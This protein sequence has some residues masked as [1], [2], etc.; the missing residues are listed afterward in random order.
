MEVLFIHLPSPDGEMSG[1]FSLVWHIFGTVID[2][3]SHMG[4]R[5]FH[6]T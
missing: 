3:D 1:D 5:R 4:Y 6:A 2:A